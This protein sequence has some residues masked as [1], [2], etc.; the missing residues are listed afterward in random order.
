[1]RLL[2][3]ALKRA[4]AFIPQRR[5]A[6]DYIAMQKKNYELRAAASKVE[7]GGLTEDY[8]VGSWREHAVWL[9]TF[10]VQHPPQPARA[11][12][13]PRGHGAASQIHHP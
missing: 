2:S 6:S 1:M 12:P 9:E 7:S 4:K 11:A 10:W 3:G 8:V 5:S 13:Q